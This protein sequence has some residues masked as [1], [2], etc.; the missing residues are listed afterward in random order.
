MQLD[1][2]RFWGRFRRLSQMKGRRTE[3]P[4]WKMMLEVVDRWKW[5]RANDPE[6]LD[7]LAHIGRRSRTLLCHLATCH[8]ILYELPE[9]DA[10]GLLA[11]IMEPPEPRWFVPR[12]A[13]EWLGHL[14]QELNLGSSD[15]LGMLDRWAAPL[16]RKPRR[17]EVF[18]NLL[19]SV[20]YNMNHYQGL[21]PFWQHLADWYRQSLP[22]PWRTKGG[23]RRRR[24]LQPYFTSEYWDRGDGPDLDPSEEGEQ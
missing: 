20:A 16:R 19:F 14:G 11:R 12:L 23:P 3:L 10:R 13:D 2:R 17:R 18:A 7:V 24:S 5:I 1:D 4:L 9:E 21:E 8:L 6:A 15:I 22:N